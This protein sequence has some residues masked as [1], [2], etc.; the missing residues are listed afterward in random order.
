LMIEAFGSLKLLRE[1][2]RVWTKSAS[3]RLSAQ[4]ALKAWAP[5]IITCA[6]FPSPAGEHLV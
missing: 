3:S 6:T 2:N 4:I 1:K 5:A